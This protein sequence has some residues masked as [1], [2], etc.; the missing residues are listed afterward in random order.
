MN[1]VQS[2]KRKI[3]D[4]CG[5][6]LSAR[7]FLRHKEICGKSDSDVESISSMSGEEERN[8]TFSDMITENANKFAKILQRRSTINLEEEDGVFFSQ[9]SSD[10]FQSEDEW[11]EGSTESDL[12]NEPCTSNYE[13]SFEEESALT[14]KMVLNWIF[15]FLVLWQSAYCIPDI[16]LVPLLKLLDAVFVCLS[17]VSAKFGTLNNIFPRDMSALRKKLFGETCHFQQYVICAKCLTLYDLSDC[18]TNLEGVQVSKTCSHME[19]PNH[20]QKHLRK[21]CG[22]ELLKCIILPSGARKLVPWYTYCYKPLVESLKLC[23]KRQDFEKKCEQWRQRSTN[24]AYLS[25]V[26]DGQMWKGFLDSSGCNYFDMP[27]HYGLI[28]NVDWFQPYKFVTYSVGVIYLAF[29]NLPRVDRYKRRNIILV[30]IIPGMKKEPSTNTFLAPLVAELLEAWDP[31][32]SL[33][34]YQSPD[35]LKRF[36]LALLC[37]GCDIPACRKVCG[38]LGHTATKGCNRCLK[39]FPGNVGQKNYGGF[40]RN[41]WKIRDR[42]THLQQVKVIQSANCKTGKKFLEGKYGC[43][44]SVLLE[45]P[46]FDPVRMATVDPMHNLFLGTAK[47]MI[48]VWKETGI[49]TDDS[50]RSLQEKVDSINCPADVGRIPRKIATGFSGFNADQFKNWTIVFSMYALREYLPTEH[51]LCWQKFVLACRILCCK[52]ISLTDIDLADQLLLAFCRKFESLY[53]ANRVTPNMHLHCHLAECLQDYGPVYGFWLFSFERENGV[54]GQ[55]PNNKRNIEAQ[56]MKR[57]LYDFQS[58]DCVLPDMFCDKFDK[59]VASLKEERKSR[60]TLGDLQL[61]NVYGVEEMKLSSRRSDIGTLKW[62][63]ERSQIDLMIPTKKSGYVNDVDY[64]HLSKMYECLYPNL[65]FCFVY[66]SCFVATQVVINDYSRLGS[67]KSRTVRSASIVA[68]WCSSGGSI[69]SQDEME[70]IPRPG[71]I[72]KFL[73]HNVKGQDGVYTHI[74]AKVK[75]FRKLPQPF[76]DKIGNIRPVSVWSNLYEDEGPASFIPIQRIKAKY[77]SASEVIDGKHVIFVCPRDKSIA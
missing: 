38:F 57:Y 13:K 71:E 51:L 58:V 11:S 34:S 77:V 72:E 61:N 27:G 1:R 54:L 12:D 47:H 30:G 48:R 2:R 24:K 65:P 20:S 75:W 40:D 62:D 29:L 60:G 6:S 52:V 21:P 37:C 28:L 69:A 5:T 17:F 10:E 44:F 56:L 76:I 4:L 59:V 9:I 7:H 32:L 23:V 33:Y 70:I 26:Y 66:K 42:T 63:F 53:G 36:K 73:I 22:Q 15:V 45:L 39:E 25:D 55:F 50:F 67:L 64:T 43:R 46:Y 68:H 31:G 16:A 18:V 35:K 8:E 41:K 49:L 74:L 3:C 19:F 14:L